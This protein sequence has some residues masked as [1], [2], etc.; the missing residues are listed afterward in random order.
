[1]LDNL[2]WEDGE[3]SK[4]WERGT[5]TK[6]WCALVVVL[7]AG[8]MAAQRAKPVFDPE[9]KDGLLIQHIQQESDAGAKLRYL[10]QFAAQYPSHP[11]AAW[12]YDQLQPMYFSLKEWD[13]A[14]HIGALRLAIEPENLE[15]AKIALRAAEA[16]QDPEQTAMWAGRAW[17]VA[18][19]IAAK[20]G[21]TAA[22]ART[23]QSYAEFCLFSAEQKTTDLHARLDLLQ[24]LDQGMPTNQYSLKLP[25]EYFG[26]Y[27]Q[28][29][30]EEKAVAMAERILQSDADNVDAIMFLA[31]SHFHKDGQHEREKVISLTGKAIDV[32]EKRP[33]P[34]SESEADWEKKKPQLLGTAY[35]MGGV[36]SSF[37]TSYTK[38]D[39]WLRAALPYLKDQGMEAAALYHLGMAN[40][41]LAD[42][43]GGPMRSMDAL[44]F[45]RRCALIR[46]P[47]QDLAAKNIE[48][49]K[50]EYNLK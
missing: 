28:I 50:K 27:R 40:Y 17:H 29:G 12:V 11:A 4:T 36:S 13:L 21:P 10:E 7:T 16:K 14:M 9:T 1:V 8:L 32:L 49:I 18:A 41:R 31:E 42:K 38:A 2:V 3:A 48:T 47:F 33:R 26:I 20:N 44:R 30:P 46:S 37:L 35:Y 34:E 22:D 15:A 19:A 25:A 23:T 24:A 5:V 45:M 43:G 39:V 6:L